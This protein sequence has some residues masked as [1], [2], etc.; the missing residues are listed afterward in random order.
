MRAN[1][2]R[3]GVVWGLAA[4]GAGGAILL[5]DPGVAAAAAAGALAIIGAIGALAASERDH[6]RRDAAGTAPKLI[7][8]RANRRRSARAVGKALTYRE[9]PPIEVCMDGHRYVV[10]VRARR[11]VRTSP[12][13][14]AP[15]GAPVDITE[16]ATL[17]RLIARAAR[18]RRA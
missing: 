10:F 8:T 2:Y 16:P 15:P 11:A 4:M 5:H 9:D 18:G 14:G 1:A 7:G 12:T 17:D 6:R 3:G 13:I